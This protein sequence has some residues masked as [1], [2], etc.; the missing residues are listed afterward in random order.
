MKDEDLKMDAQKEN[1]A[2]FPRLCRA[3]TTDYAKAAITALFAALLA[4]CELFSGLCPFGIAF[5]A[6]V[7]GFAPASA[8]AAAGMFA[9]ALSAR[10]N[11]LALYVIAAIAAVFGIRIL[12][13]RLGSDVDSGAS[14]SGDGGLANAAARLWLRFLSVMP[15]VAFSETAITKC[16]VSGVAALLSYAMA[17]V[18]SGKPSY[19]LAALF[20][21]LVVPALTYAFCGIADE[22]IRDSSA[23]TAGAAVLLFGIVT[24]MRDVRLLGI[25]PASVLAYSAALWVSEYRGASKGAV[26]GLLSGIALTPM[27]PPAY[28]IGPLAA[29]ILWKL[30]PVSAVCVSGMISLAWTAYA[31][32]LAAVTALLPSVCV[33]LAVY[34]PLAHFGVLKPKEKEKPAEADSAKAPFAA[35]QISGAYRTASDMIAA[36]T[37]VADVFTSLSDK[38]KSP[39]AAEI[40]NICE[41]ALR[42]RCISCERRSDCFGGDRS[43]GGR[44][45]ENM[46]ASLR[47]H[48]RISSACVPESIASRCGKMAEIIDDADAEYA[49]AARM[50]SLEDKTAVLGENYSAVAAML[51]GVLERQ[52]DDFMPDESLAERIGQAMGAGGITAETVAVYGCSKKRIYVGGLDMAKT[53]LTPAETSALL[54]GISGVRLGEPEYA[55]SGG[56]CS[57]TLT[58]LPTV[59][60]RHGRYSVAGSDEA[61]GDSAV[62]FANR[63]GRF[64]SLISDGMG[65][66]REAALT[67]H[68]ASSFLLK[69]LGSGAGMAE[70]LRMLNGFIRAGRL[71][72]S[73][74][75]D[76][77]ELD[78]YTG[79]A[80]FVKSGAAPTFIVRSGK[81]FRIRSKTVP[82]GI[83]RALDAEM[84]TVP[85]KEGD[86]VVMFSDGI[87]GGSDDSA[88][89]ID[90]L[91]EHGDRMA[92]PA[93]AARFIA[94]QSAVRSGRKAPDDAT[95]TV[96]KIVKR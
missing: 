62:C 18:I 54:T 4:P 46:V 34:A 84:I 57:M 76:L 93:K 82:I 64:Y 63:D 12:L 87:A 17:A 43:D 2:V 79:E 90:L 60:V 41:T 89:L 52:K 66:G 35:E 44:M 47:E 30:S 36:M 33:S 74:T 58:A 69:M 95:V 8:A 49:K 37:S 48:G 7:N 59:A 31:G 68:I 71:E 15:E 13:G 92:D 22:K 65:S 10:H 23:F 72:C 50:L 21:A 83:L 67:S 94:E 91:T 55:L 27:Y 45:T 32:G 96:M 3:L 11:S 53:K 78:L 56:R 61:N 39:S 6:S 51:R 20:A 24:A 9:V 28:A 88:W 73:A 5:A 40:R 86:T 81:I 70:S 25:S 29:G 1:S 80:R 26:A 75:V 38:L 77:F 14:P 85:M 19:L 16:V 42:S